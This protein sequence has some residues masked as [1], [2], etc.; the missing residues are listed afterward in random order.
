MGG[1]G[2]SEVHVRV[3]Q[4]PLD[5]GLRPGGDTEGTQR[6]ELGRPDCTRVPLAEPA[7]KQDAQAKFLGQR[8]GRALGFALSWVVGHL[9]GV[10]AAGGHELC[11]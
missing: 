6:R 11:E 8:Q 2:Q 1:G 10:H 7:H 3:A 4:A 5:Q 9:D